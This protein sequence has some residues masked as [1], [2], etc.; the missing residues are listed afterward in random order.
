M[1]IIALV[2]FRDPVCFLST[3]CR[4][5]TTP[6]HIPDGNITLESRFP[7]PAYCLST[8]HSKDTQNLPKPPRA[9]HA[10]STTFQTRGIF[11]A[12]G[13]TKTAHI[14]I[15]APHAINL[16]CG[17]DEQQG[18]RIG[19][20]RRLRRCT[21]AWWPLGRVCWRR[22]TRGRPFEGCRTAAARVTS[23][24]RCGYSSTYMHDGM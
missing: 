15:S 7:G 6:A 2:F 8:Y 10:R 5:H 11:Q 24:G 9:S 20:R 4:G 16:C 22:S 14:Y 3:T 23:T 12:H 19:V 17:D 21:R 18:I 1:P 13:H